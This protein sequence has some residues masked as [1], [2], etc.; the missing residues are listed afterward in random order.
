VLVDSEVIAL[1][2]ELEMLRE[3]G[4]TFDRT[5]YAIRFM[6]LSTEA[7]HAAIDVEAQAKL[8]RPISQAIR[9]SD[10]L[11]AVMV[12]K[13]T[14]V[15]GAAEAV[16]ALTLPKA[17]ASSGSMDGLER[18]LKRTGLWTLFA[19]HIYG[20]DHVR[21]AKPAPDLFLHAAA[22]LDVPPAQC[23]VLEDSLNG[24]VAARAAGMTVWGFLGGGHASPALGARLLEAGAERLVA[25][26]L[27]ASRLLAGLGR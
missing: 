11:R 15:A 22:A 23:L 3:Q 9:Q 14:Q 4:L 21:A 10:R 13:L 19:P 27:E 16:A 6:G 20:A 5:D 25:D 26:W 7:Y 17:I 2:V 12:A 1:E 24:V 8:G 18:K